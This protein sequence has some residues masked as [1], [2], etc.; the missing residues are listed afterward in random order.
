MIEENEYEPQEL[1]CP[2][3]CYTCDGSGIVNPLTSPDGFFC[4]VSTTCPDCEGSGRL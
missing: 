4:A 2:D 1:S 3:R